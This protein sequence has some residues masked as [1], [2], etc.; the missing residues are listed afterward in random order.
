[1]TINKAKTGVFASLL[2]TAADVFAHPGHD[3]GH[4]LSEPIHALSALAV[5]SVTAVVASKWVKK[6][7]NNNQ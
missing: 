7:S 1:M 3:H 2:V 4:W 5:I 6:R